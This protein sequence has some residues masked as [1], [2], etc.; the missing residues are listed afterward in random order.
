MST[1]TLITNTG[2]LLNAEGYITH[3]GI[4]VAYCSLDG[5]EYIRVG[6]SL[7]FRP[8]VLEEDGRFTCLASGSVILF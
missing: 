4:E 6:A 5:D 3:R 1:E 2:T 7:M 8:D